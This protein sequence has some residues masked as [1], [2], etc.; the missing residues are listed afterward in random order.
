VLAENFRVFAIDLLG[1]GAS[2]KPTPGVV[3]YTFETW[4]QQVADFCREVVGAPAFLVGNSVG[5]LVAMQTAVDYA[6]GVRGVALL[7]CSLRL[8]HD[9]RREAQPLV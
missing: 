4:G 3:E 7:N 6:D 5:C 8:L 1:F 2:A 9:R